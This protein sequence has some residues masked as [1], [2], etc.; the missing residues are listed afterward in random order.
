RA[1][2]GAVRIPVAVKLSPFYSALAHFAR[3]L[4]EA[5]VDA[6]VLFNRFYQP[7]IDAEQLEVT[8]GIKLSD[9]SE[10]LLRLR[11]LAILSGR[12]RASLAATGGVH[13]A[14]DAV[15]A[16]MAG[17]RAV[18]MVSALL[19]RGPEYL[20]EVRQGMARWMEEHGYASL[21]EM[22]GSMSLLRC[23]NPGA[24]ERANYVKIL[25]GWNT[26]GV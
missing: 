25:Q 9:P 18:Q 21:A 2:K 13:T 20:A 6:L 4:D 8:R 10:L 1:V 22:Q 23:D 17:A 11:W 16:V 19:G 26:S 24:Y 5:G 3:R 14:L 15:K 7:D 12:V